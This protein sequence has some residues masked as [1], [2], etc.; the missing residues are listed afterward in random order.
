MPLVS[1]N[2]FLERYRSASHDRLLEI[3]V[4]KRYQFHEDAIAAAEQVLEERGISVADAKWEID[5][6]EAERREL[7]DL[8][9]KYRQL[10][11]DEE[12]R[13]IAEAGR[14]SGR[15]LLTGAPATTELVVY[16]RRDIEHKVVDGVEMSSFDLL[17]VSIPLSEAAAHKHRTIR[18]PTWFLLLFFGSAAW[19][20]AAAKLDLG[21]VLMLGP[22]VLVMLTYGLVEAQQWLVAKR[23]FRAHPLYGELTRRG[24]YAIS[25]ERTRQPRLEILSDQLKQHRP[26]LS[27][28]AESQLVARAGA[29]WWPAC[30]SCE[31]PAV[32]DL[33]RAVL[34][35]LAG[36]G[37][38]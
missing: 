17:P 11:R 16:L 21:L 2:P 36:Q 13:R 37:R 9:Q 19:M 3:A 38:G 23:L 25:P 33:A 12:I 20:L 34:E 22:V 29:R 24:Y 8:N 1:E 18:V 6:Q 26:T 10:Q 31:S 14:A 28:Y 32:S 27:S 35:N 7:T 4:R 15:C 30:S 5:E